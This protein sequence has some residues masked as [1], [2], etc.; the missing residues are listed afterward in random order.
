MYMEHFSVQT[1]SFFFSTPLHF[2]FTFFPICCET[3]SAIGLVAHFFFLL[4][5]AL[6]AGK[7]LMV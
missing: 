7:L 6:L 3:I 1:S 2:L 5:S 4:Y